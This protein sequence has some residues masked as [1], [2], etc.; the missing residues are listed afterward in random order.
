MSSCSSE[1]S[2]KKE[3]CL[4]CSHYSGCNG[5]EGGFLGDRIQYETKGYCELTKKETSANRWCSKYRRE[6]SIAMA[7]ANKER[8][9]SERRQK[10]AEYRQKNQERLERQA[11]ERR[12]KEERAALERERR[13]LG[14]ERKRLQYERWYVSLTPEEQEAEDRRVKEEEERQRILKEQAEL[15]FQEYLK[16]QAEEQRIEKEKAKKRKKI[17]IGIGIGAAALAVLIPVG[18]IGGQALAAYSKQKAFE[19]SATGRFLEHIRGLDGHTID[20]HLIE[21]YGAYADIESRGRVYFTLEYRTNYFE[22]P[23]G[24]PCDFRAITYLLPKAGESY[25]EIDSYLFF[26]LEGSDN[27]PSFKA[28]DEVKETTV[29]SYSALSQYGSGTVITQYKG[30]GYDSSKGEPVYDGYSL[31]YDNWDH[32]YDIYQEEWVGSGWTACVATYM[33]VNELFNE[34]TGG[35]LH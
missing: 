13:D 30:I 7:I 8:K 17:L 16:K 34:A 1:F 22:D 32:R 10:D 26:N 9:E 23:N 25:T 27:T 21:K 35:S 18:I 3:K 12:Q 6:A 19:E 33:F 28:G 4:S 2:L 14:E 29:P 15:E 5:I 20:I 31:S 11:I 24:L